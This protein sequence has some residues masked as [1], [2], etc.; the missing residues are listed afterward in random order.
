ML[1]LV[2]LICSLR[3]NIVF[4]IIFA[5][6]FAG[7]LLLTATFW[8]TADANSEA[9]GKTL[10]LAGAVTFGADMAGWYLLLS[11]LLTSVD[12]PIVLPLGDLSGWIKGLSQKKAI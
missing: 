2:Y 5:C 10:F 11:L 3:T 6:L 1:S 7:F 9:A 8:L 4:V 12:F